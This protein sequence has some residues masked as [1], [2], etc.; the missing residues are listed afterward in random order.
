MLGDLRID[1]LRSG[2]VGHAEV[3]LKEQVGYDILK[4]WQVL[5]HYYYYHHILAD[6]Q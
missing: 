2:G 5:Y 3:I 4:P 1:S 6:K